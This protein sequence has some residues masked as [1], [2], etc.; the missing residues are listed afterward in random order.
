MA[1][2]SAGR[3]LLEVL[4]ADDPDLERFIVAV[5][6]IYRKGEDDRFDFKLRWRRAGKDRLRRCR[7]D[8]TGS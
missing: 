5:L 8:K 4:E 3:S 6:R 2:L 7:T 1:I